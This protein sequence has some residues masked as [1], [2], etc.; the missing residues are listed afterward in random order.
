MTFN[1]VTLQAF[2]PN[3]S[4]FEPSDFYG[5]LIIAANNSSIELAPADTFHATNTFAAGSRTGNGSVTINGWTGARGSS[6]TDD[7]I[8]ITVAPNADF[9]NHINFGV[10]PPG[11]ARLTSGELVP[12][13]D[14]AVWNGGGGGDTSWSTTANWVNGTAPLN[15]GTP[16][17]VFGG[18]TGLGPIT[19]SN[20]G[21][22]GS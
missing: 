9:L 4:P 10:L 2:G 7:Q 20:W 16:L 14:P 6:G 18:T 19:D 11:A 22:L 8:F 5:T 12:V 1:G 15:N 3:P 17:V 13:P 21:I